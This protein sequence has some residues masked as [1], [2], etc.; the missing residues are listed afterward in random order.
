MYHMDYLR[1][2]GEDSCKPWC[3]VMLLLLASNLGA[4]EKNPV[5]R[6]TRAIMEQIFDAIA[7]VLPYSASAARLEGH[8][9]SDFARSKVEA[10]TDA[11]GVLVAH[12]LG[13]EKESQYLARSMHDTLRDVKDAFEEGDMH[14][15]YF[16]LSDV[17]Q[18]CATCHSRT[19]ERDEYTLGQ[20]LMARMDVDK[21]HR[22]DL[23]SLYV[24]TRQFDAAL[25]VLE[26]ILLDPAV[27]P[28]ES[29]MSGTFLKYL[30]VGFSKRDGS[31][32]L[33]RTI[34]SVLD[35]DD[36]P[37]YLRRTLEGWRSDIPL[38][39]QTLAEETTFAQGRKLFDLATNKTAVSASGRRAV[40]DLAAANLLRRF[41]ENEP[42]ADGEV[43][44]EAYYLL[45]LVALRT[46][47][48]YSPAV[49]EM[50][51]LLEA[52]IR[53]APRGKF[54]KDAYAMLEEFGVV[55]GMSLVD[56][57]SAHGL[58]N[59]DELAGLIGIE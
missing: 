33:I 39:F 46:G 21:L 49:P 37:F 20:R 57:E 13:K 7:F 45:A 42:A 26:R 47:N 55:N 6:D 28:V 56:L 24:A 5:D 43:L 41:I 54:A 34:S 3:V 11:A 22:E 18:Y 40:L 44:A 48:Y 16:A 59:L 15:M 35:R 19:Q 50:E 10:L 31:E 17:T 51:L 53:S 38:V 25:R 27:S 32:R 12:T 29:D 58:M 23:A 9:A 36:L 8:E 1:R 4:E 30:K 2:I 14:W 52:S